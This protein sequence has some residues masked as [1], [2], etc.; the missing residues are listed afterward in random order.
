MSIIELRFLILAQLGIDIVL[1]LVFIMVIRRLRSFNKSKSFVET[2]KTFQ[3][4]VSDADKIADQFNE[5][6]TEKHEA[7]KRLNE[8]L[9]KRIGSLNILLNR[10]DIML[11]SKGEEVVGHNNRDNVSNNN[12]SNNH[13]SNN[14]QTEIIRMA[15]EGCR[16]EE[17]AG[18]LSI[19]KG[20]VKLVLDLKKT[21]YQSDKK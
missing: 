9:D 4:F 2:I 8:Q 11:S 7:I 17:I 6:L 19:P 3:S 21:F 12:A 16:L 1:I 14:H 13:A 18:R 5:Q 10:A 15:K 20:E